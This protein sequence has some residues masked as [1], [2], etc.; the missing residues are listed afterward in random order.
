MS[1]EKTPKNNNISASV[2]INTLESDIKH[3]RQLYY[4]GTPEISDA[5][6]DSLEDA[7][8]ELDPTNALFSEVGRD[9]SEMFEKRDHIIPMGSQDKVTTHEDF[10][11]WAKKRDYSK[12]LVQFKLDGISIET[13][14]NNGMFQHAVTRGDGKKGDDVTANVRKMKGFVPKLK[15]KFTGGIRGEVL[16][17][18]DIF[19]E[20]YSDKQNCRN[21]AAGIVRRK[22]GKGSE[23]LNIIHYDAISLTDDV[24]FDSETQKIKWLN[25]EGF[26]TI[27]TKTANTPQEVIK[28]REEVMNNLRD[29][30]DYDIDGLVIKGNKID[31]DDMKRARPMKQIAFKFQAEEMETVV[32]GIEWSQNGH[33]YTPVA[34]IETI[35][36]MGSNLS[37]ASLANPNLI[38]ELDLKI[39]SEV[40]VSKRGDVI[41]KIERILKTPVDAREIEVPKICEICNTKLNNEGTR[42]YCPNDNCPKRHYHRL[43]KWIK[44]LEIKNFSEKLILQRLFSSGKVQRIA[45]LYS[46]KVHD[47]TQFD[48]VKDTSA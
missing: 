19:N 48:G 38:K 2:R 31:L 46:L 42:L 13:Q 30:L 16:L 1:D 39:G 23:D 25:E 6:Y 45:D 20:K 4:N 15:S 43:I 14:Y 44:T 8:R 29:T 33:N 37:R 36:L 21:T 24:S 11:K 9:T 7:L 32:L 35:N 40:M 41:P 28:I 26:P 34:L 47:L 18:H 12:F 22:D 27:K 10:K 5:K 3:H 17:L